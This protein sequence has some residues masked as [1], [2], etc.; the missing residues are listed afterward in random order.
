MKI[1]L[2]PLLVAALVFTTACS[3]G[4]E[5]GPDSGNDGGFDA[6]LSDAGSGDSGLPDT[7][8]PVTVSGNTF[9]FG[10][11]P[12]RVPGATVEVLGFPHL[13]TITDKD[14]FFSLQVVKGTDVA[15]VMNHPDYHQMITGTHMVGEAGLEKLTFQAVTHQF[16]AFLGDIA[17]A[18][19]RK[20]RCQITSTVTIKGGSLYVG[21]ATHGEK[22][23]TV[24]IDPPLPPEYGP[25]YFNRWENG[26]VMPDK[27]LTETTVDGGILYLNVPPGVYTIT[28]HKQGMTFTTAKFQCVAGYLVNASPPW[29]LQ[30]Q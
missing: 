6:A 22:G 27:S 15:L 25:I 19:P 20:D 24:T 10:P 16:Y 13:N 3:T 23:A 14:G 4:H 12:G 17:G 11:N 8:A 5:G 30:A 9:I 29:A 28:A 26:Y 18:V 7:G 2:E 21:G 1:R